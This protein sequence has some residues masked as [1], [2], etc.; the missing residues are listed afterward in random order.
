M[1]LVKREIRYRQQIRYLFPY[2]PQT[3]SSTASEGRKREW[4]RAKGSFTP[5]ASR[6]DT[7]RAKC[8][9]DFVARTATYRNM[10]QDAVTQRKATQRNAQ[11]Q[12]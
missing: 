11:H 9:V 12:M 3:F 4:N 6:C 5:D 10:P 8:C 2:A 7:A 1:S